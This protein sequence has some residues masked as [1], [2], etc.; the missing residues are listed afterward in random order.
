MG[1]N[2]HHA[3]VPGLWGG[4]FRELL[5]TLHAP[6]VGVWLWEATEP[7]S[8][9]GGE[10]APSLRSLG[11]TEARDD[12]FSVW[13]IPDVAVCYR[14]A[15]NKVGCGGHQ[16]QLSQPWSQKKKRAWGVGALGGFLAGES[17]WSSPWLEC[18]KAFRG[19]F[20]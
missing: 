14:R 10:G 20:K 18:R 13:D 16:G 5:C 12:R 8:A 6:W 2:P 4:R 17:S 15:E 9:G 3:R 11:L 1:E 7:Q 19:F